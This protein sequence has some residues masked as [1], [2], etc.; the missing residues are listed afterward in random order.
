MHR[1]GIVTE[2]NAIERTARV[3]FRDLNSTVSAV[4]PYAKHLSIDINDRVVVLF[5]SANLADGLIVA[6]Y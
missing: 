6:T 1:K 2:V 3:T 5:F 4:L